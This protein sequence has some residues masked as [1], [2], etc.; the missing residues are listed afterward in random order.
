MPAEEVQDT[1]L[2]EVTPLTGKGALGKWRAS[3]R[4]TY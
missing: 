2:K 3:N 1:F 4:N